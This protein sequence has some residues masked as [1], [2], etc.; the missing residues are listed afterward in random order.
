[1]SQTGSAIQ[2][3]TIVAQIYS[4][5][6]CSTLSPVFPSRTEAV[7]IAE[8][9]TADL[10][11]HGLMRDLT[12]RIIETTAGGVLQAEHPNDEKYAKWFEEIGVT[13]DLLARRREEAVFDASDCRSLDLKY[14]AT[15]LLPS[16]NVQHA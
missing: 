12:S 11:A 6:A 10:S 5:H 3:A 9:T 4:W 2:D 14:S 7:S 15:L 8:H 13:I 1:M 16:Q